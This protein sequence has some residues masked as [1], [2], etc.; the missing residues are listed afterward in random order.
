MTAPLRC[1]S[2][3]VLAGVRDAAARARPRGADDAAWLSA[4]RSRGR[5]Q[6]GTR[7]VPGTMGGC[8][9]PRIDWLIVGGESGPHARPCNLAWIRSAVAQCRAAGVPVFV[10]QLGGAD[11]PDSVTVVSGMR[12]RDRAGADPSEGPEDLRVREWPR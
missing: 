5:G 10:K 9:R 12:Y 3:G 2:C 4:P 11:G 7:S 8:C 6:R 1:R